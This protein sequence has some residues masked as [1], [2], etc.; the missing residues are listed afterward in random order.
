MRWEALLWRVWPKL[1]RMHQS[2]WF[3]YHKSTKRVPTVDQ[4]TS[5]ILL[6]PNLPSS[7]TRFF[8]SL[9]FYIEWQPLFCIFRTNNSERLPDLSSNPYGMASSLNN[10]ELMQQDGRLR[11][12][13]TLFAKRDNNFVCNN[14]SPN[15]TFH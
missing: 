10:R 12:Q 3:V 14:F 13:Q 6:P 1:W 2:C 5:P 15:F 9:F 4:V 8:P 7:V 11:G